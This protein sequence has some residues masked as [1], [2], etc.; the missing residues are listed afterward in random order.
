MT[1]TNT[2]SI[3]AQQL[4]SAALG[5]AIH[6]DLYSAEGA[7]LYAKSVHTDTVECAEVRQVGDLI[8][9]NATVGELAAGE[10]R[11]LFSLPEDKVKIY[12]ALDTS[13][14]LLGALSQRAKDAGIPSEQIHI[15]QQDITTWSPTPK[16]FDLLILGAG[17][18]RLFPLSQRQTL[19]E[20]VHLALKPGGYFY[21]STSEPMNGQDGFVC[22]GQI[23]LRSSNVVVYFFESR[24]D[25]LAAREIGFI[26]FPIGKKNAIPRIYKSTVYDLAC[27]ELSTE[28]QIAGF[29]LVDEITNKYENESGIYEKT[30]AFIVQK[31]S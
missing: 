31:E 8:P 16:T 11:L 28:L 14:L 19:Y 7:Q 10:G 18:I 2:A 24:L 25:N 27:E 9:P 21:I 29:T 23:R 17:T 6:K 4:F 5:S 20:I 26:V 3:S 12:T 15:L 1:N 13:P 22:L 30:T